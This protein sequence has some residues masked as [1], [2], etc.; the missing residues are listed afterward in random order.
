M[1]FLTVYTSGMANVGMAVLYTVARIM[2]IDARGC[3]RNNY[4]GRFDFTN[5]YANISIDMHDFDFC[6]D[7]VKI[8]AIKNMACMGAAIIF[9]PPRTN[10]ACLDCMRM[11]SYANNRTWDARPVWSS[12]YPGVSFTNTVTEIPGSF[13]VLLIYKIDSPENTRA[14]IA[15]FLK[16]HR[17]ERVFID[18]EYGNFLCVG[19]AYDESI[20]MLNEVFSGAFTD[21]EKFLR[22]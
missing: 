17:P 21:Y 1:T 7:D 3:T 22:N 9:V 14:A 5:N 20:R 15:D 16:K 10:S 18:G 13:P 2:G 11:V 6:D 19:P 4:D 12:S 8:C